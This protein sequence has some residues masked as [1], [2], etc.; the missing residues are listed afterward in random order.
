[1]LWL[2]ALVIAS[3]LSPIIA[4]HVSLL[5]DGSAIWTVEHRFPLLKPEEAEAFG[6][7]SA[8]SDNLTLEYREAVES[9][10][11]EASFTLGR[12]M[13]IEDFRIE[14][15]TA[16]TMSGEIGLIKITFVWRGFSKPLESGA[17]EL[18]D[19]FIGGFYLADGETL[20][21]TAPEGFRVSE[22][23][24]APD[25]LSVDYVEWR[26]RIVFSD[27]EPRLVVN[28]ASTASQTPQTIMMDMPPLY[29][30]AASAL[31]LSVTLV[32]LR[33]RRR[34]PLR[35]SE[36]DTVL[37]IIKSHGGVIYQSQIVRES[38]LSKSTVSTIL[39][40]LESEGRV[41]REREGRENLVR[42]AR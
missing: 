3:T 26:G 18:G 42:L 32:I 39:K 38:G 34:R 30:L 2:V 21:I 10:V 19:V 22:A 23:R 33:R 8:R 29:A 27:G 14:L 35:E 16:K 25:T 13:W 37:R 31:A 36:L 7:L 28:P 9:I 15:K 24:P 6:R 1:M 41:V 40:V 11:S 20:R 4:Y 5:P 17:L 12:S